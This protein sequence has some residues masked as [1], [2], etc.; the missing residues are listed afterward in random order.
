MS[1]LVKKTVLTI[2]VSKGLKLGG[3]ELLAEIDTNKSDKIIYW[4]KYSLQ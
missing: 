2:A 4:M 1:Q 3:E